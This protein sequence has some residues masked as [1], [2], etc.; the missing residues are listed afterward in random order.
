MGEKFE[1]VLLRLELRSFLVATPSCRIT[2]ELA[3]VQVDSCL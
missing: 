2:H 3:V 1:V